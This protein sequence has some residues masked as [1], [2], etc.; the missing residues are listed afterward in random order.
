MGGYM[1]QDNGV[2]DVHGTIK[3]RGNIIDIYLFHY[4]FMYQ[5]KI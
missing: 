4:I 5:N 3:W 1:F 2:E